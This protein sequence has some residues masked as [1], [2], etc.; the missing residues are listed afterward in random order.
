MAVNDD[1][2]PERM[3][4]T[5]DRMLTTGKLSE[6][7]Y[8]VVMTT[9]HF[10]ALLVR[11]LN[12]IDHPKTVAPEPTKKQSI[13]KF[14]KLQAK[15]VP[16]YF[17]ILNNDF[18]S[19]S[20]EKMI[21]C[22]RGSHRLISFDNYVFSFGG[23]CP[24]G[25]NTGKMSNAALKEIWKFNLLTNIWTRIE[26][27]GNMPDHVISM[28]ASVYRKHVILFGG[29]ALPL[30]YRLSNEVYIFSLIT[31]KFEKLNIIGNKPIPRYQHAMCI[32]EDVLY[33]HGGLN[34]EYV[35][36][37]LYAMNL[38]DFN[39]LKWSSLNPSKKMP[40][41]GHTMF[42]YNKCIYLM[43]K[44]GP[45]D[46]IS[47]LTFFNLK[48]NTWNKITLHPD[49]RHG[50][51]IART[52][53]NQSEFENCIY[54]CGGFNFTLL[55]DAWKLDLK[56]FTWHKLPCNLPVKCCFHGSTITSDGSWIVFGGNHN[57][58]HSEVRS[59]TI[60][61][62]RLKIPSLRTLAIQE[63]IKSNPGVQFLPPV[64]NRY[65]GVPTDMIKW[66]ENK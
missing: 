51:P 16:E 8:Q 53:H 48:S 9:S 2:A 1:N 11:H 41:F 28:T 24:S 54:I 26:P 31:M 17:R 56:T 15:P 40:M 12:R 32:Y 66:I 55:N 4:T 47:Y 39:N 13:F 36:G 65:N 44:S 14:Q 43:C 21:P 30:G 59:N 63:Y 37:E 27:I 50:Y 58:L 57:T 29:T 25:L 49:E 10:N 23:Y 60:Y 20:A 7:F 3:Y 52:M 42:G 18:L 38:K 45:F 64:L 35:D 19:T 33:V 61:R 5:T 22:C 6:Q 62:C 34:D 46:N